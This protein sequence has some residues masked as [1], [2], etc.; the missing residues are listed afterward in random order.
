MERIEAYLAPSPRHAAQWWL[1]SGV[2]F[3]LAACCASALH[4]QY[5]ELVQRENELAQLQRLRHVSPPAAPT[6]ADLDL[7]KQWEDLQRE[8]D[9]SWYPIFAALENASSQQV[10]LLEFVPDKTTR[11]MILR[12]NA[13]NIDALSAY[14]DALGAQDG[15]R[16]V[17]LAHQKAIQQAGGTAIFFEIRMRI[18]E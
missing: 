12:G 17:H 13:K 7:R 1:A 2:A 16:E 9:F 4:W 5:G 8:L 11:R 10:A 6:R 15:F 3:A 14:L 18:L